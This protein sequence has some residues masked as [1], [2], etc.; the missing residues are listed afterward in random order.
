LDYRK[1]RKGYLYLSWEG[2][3][4]KQGVW[5]GREGGKGEITCKGGRVRN[6]GSK[7]YQWR[8]WEDSRLPRERP[9]ERGSRKGQPLL[10]I[11][12]KKGKEKEEG[13]GGTDYIYLFEKKGEGEGERRT[14]NANSIHWKDGRGKKRFRRTLFVNKG[15][16]KR[17]RVGKG[18]CKIKHLVAS[19]ALLF[20]RKGGEGGSLVR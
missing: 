5:G 2:A 12:E 1:K 10:S 13:H 7:F 20:E 15:R 14:R 3:K 8:E 18:S 16:K 19:F 11:R 4:K 17:G 9:R 6:R